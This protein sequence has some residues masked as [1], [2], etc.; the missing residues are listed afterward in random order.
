MPFLGLNAM[1]YPEENREGTSRYGLFG[2][3]PSLQN[4]SG[5]AS[6]YNDR[7]LEGVP[8]KKMYLW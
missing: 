2:D 4:Y 6:G 7:K 8:Y 5:Y 1:D 3:F